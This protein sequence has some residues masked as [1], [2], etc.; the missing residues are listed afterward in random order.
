MDVGRT[1]DVGSRFKKGI[2]R[3]S[4]KRGEVIN[5]FFLDGF[6]LLVA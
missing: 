6:V 1:N 2:Q 4:L 3:D 5:I